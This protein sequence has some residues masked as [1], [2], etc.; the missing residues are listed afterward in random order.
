MFKRTVS[1]VAVAAVLAVPAAALADDGTQPARPNAG[2]R[3]ARLLARI[4]R[5]EARLT[6]IEARIQQHCASAQADDRCSRA[7]ARLQTAQDR[8]AKLK[9]KI[10]AWLQNHGSRSSGTPG[11]DDAQALSQLQQ[12]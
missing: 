12:A 2:A 9:A 11:S 8:A 4:S 10:E 1:L 5:V 3:A 6:R 7:E